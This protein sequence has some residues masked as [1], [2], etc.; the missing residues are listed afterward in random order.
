METK[1]RKIKLSSSTYQEL[2]T[3]L[4]PEWRFMDE[5]GGLV[6]ISPQG[7][8]LH[9]FVETIAEKLEARYKAYVDA[10]ESGDLEAMRKFAPR[11]KTY[12]EVVKPPSREELQRR[13]D[14]VNKARGVDV[15]DTTEGS[16]QE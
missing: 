9:F 13:I 7:N 1:H 3:A 14:A 11:G 6:L 2:I 5:E 15:S 10:C 8:R 4:A 12:G 16:P